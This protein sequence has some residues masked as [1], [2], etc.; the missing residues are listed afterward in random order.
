[1]RRPRTSQPAEALRPS[2]VVHFFVVPQLTYLEAIRPGIWEEM[3]RDPA[4]FCIGEDI[5][6][7]VAA[8]KVTD[9]FLDRFGPVRVID[10]PIAE[11]GIV[12]AAFVASI[13]G[14]RPAA[15]VQLL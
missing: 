3:E 10:T 2:N 11:S 1:M 12:G 4:V 15:P 9:G 6:I 5:R 13:T 14:I 7:Y 8:F